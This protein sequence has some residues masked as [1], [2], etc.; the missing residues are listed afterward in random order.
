MGRT[1][2]HFMQAGRHAQGGA[3]LVTVMVMLVVIGLTAAA[4][5]RS[6]SS[7]ERFIRNTRLQQLTQQYAETA[8]RYCE[9]ELVKSDD[10]SASGGLRVPT[11]A[12]PN[13]VETAWD[14][15]SG[16]G[17]PASW[18]NASG[19]IASSRTV[20]P[21]AY[22]QSTDSSFAPGRLPE[23]VVEKQVLADGNKVYVIT[24]RGF[25]P[26]YEAEGGMGATRATRHG[27]VVWMQSIV[28]L[29]SQTGQ[30][31]RDR[32]WR[33]IINPPIR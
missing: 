6:A 21:Q 7:G 18:T 24:A 2:S 29:E 30:G 14:A 31:I 25:S 3:A 23:C 13:L 17:Q 19:G 27:A 15:P 33:R 28:L 32:I 5:L 10:P 11:L 22:V 4:V 8:L 20:V 12:E 9:A 1:A 26:G 16:W